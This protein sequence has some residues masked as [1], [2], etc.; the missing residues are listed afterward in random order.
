ME[1]N[2]FPII[3]VII[4]AYN[5]EQ[6]IDKCVS[7]ILLQD[8]QNIEI[9]IVNDGSTDATAQICDRLRKNDKRI[10][11]ID[12]ENGGVSS[13]RNCGLSCASGEYIMFCDS[14]DYPLQGWI[15][16]L[17][18]G[19][20]HEKID[21]AMCR[22]IRG[23]EDSQITLTGDNIVYKKES[24]WKL[25]TEILL[26]SPVNKIYKREIIEEN[27]LKFN[28]RKSNGE[29]LSFNLEYLSHCSGDI[30]L[31]QDTLYYYNYTDSG[32]TASYVPNFWKIKKESMEE[33]RIKMEQFVNFKTIEKEYYT[34]YLDSVLLCINNNM[35]KG[36][37]IPFFVRFLENCKI[38]RSEEF[39]TSLKKSDTKNYNKWFVFVLNT[40]NYFLLYIFRRLV[41]L[42]KV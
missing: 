25:F 11:V 24:A 20:N 2:H 33:L 1:K 29:D 28:T 23:G 6:T 13:A 9:I 14:D 37:G 19:I 31:V 17:Y 39:Y 22:Y 4:P 40:R 36:S 8:Y 15:S 42:K 30:F 5:A 34:Y 12:K 3:T 10:R 16:K 26:T 35:K 27:H 21:L 18:E 41:E 7:E 38:M 32:L